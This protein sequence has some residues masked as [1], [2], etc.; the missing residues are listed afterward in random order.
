MVPPYGNT[1]T[2]IIFNEVSCL[3]MTM[4]TSYFSRMLI[5][6]ALVLYIFYNL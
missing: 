4:A 5:S 1:Q 2:Y 3:T 6:F